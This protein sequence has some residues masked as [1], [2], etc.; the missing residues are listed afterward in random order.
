MAHLRDAKGVLKLVDPERRNIKD[1]AHVGG[2][3]TEYAQHK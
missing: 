2:G 3:E 1:K